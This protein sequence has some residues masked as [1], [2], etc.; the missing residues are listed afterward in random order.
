[1]LHWVNVAFIEDMATWSSFYKGI[2]EQPAMSSLGWDI[3]CCA[4]IEMFATRRWESIMLSPLLSLGGTAGI[5]RG[6][7]Q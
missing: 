4:V 3:V 1:L 7:G 5:F 6:M 2:E